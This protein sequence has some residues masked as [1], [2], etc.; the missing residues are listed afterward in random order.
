M[1]PQYIQIEMELRKKILDGLSTFK[2]ELREKAKVPHEIFEKHVVRD[3]LR[4]GKLGTRVDY[5]AP[6]IVCYDSKGNPVIIIEVKVTTPLRREDESHLEQGL[7]RYG[8]SYGILTNGRS[9]LLYKFS[10]E[11]GARKITNMEIDRITGKN[12]KDLSI[13]EIVQLDMLKLMS[14][15]VY[16]RKKRKP[17]PPKLKVWTRKELLRETVDEA[18]RIFQEHNVETEIKVLEKTKEDPVIGIEITGGLADVGSALRR[19][20]DWIRR[21]G[22]VHIKYKN[23]EAAKSQAVRDLEEQIRHTDHEVYQS[24]VF[25][26]GVFYFVFHDRLSD[27]YHLYLITRGCNIK[28]RQS[29]RDPNRLLRSLV[30]IKFTDLSRI[31]DYIY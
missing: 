17:K 23:V 10:P 9:L 27:Q 12:L 19:F 14:R 20:F 22:G 16:G 1:A 18:K 28:Y 25:P 26:N 5:V 7:R 6:D 3:S 4:W 29:E 8:V 15:Y 2:N 31:P 24:G 11:T 21:R 13:G 30:T